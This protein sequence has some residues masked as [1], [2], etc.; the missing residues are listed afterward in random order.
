MGS[1]K[2]NAG[3]GR[4]PSHQSHLPVAGKIIA[5]VLGKHSKHEPGSF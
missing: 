3:A 2:W 5:K 1:G 4:V